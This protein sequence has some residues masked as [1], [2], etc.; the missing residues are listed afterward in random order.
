MNK[1]NRRN[2]IKAG[3]ALLAVGSLPL[4]L[5]EIA[6]GKSSPENFTFAY[7]SDS[8]ITH[9]KGSSFVNNWDRGLIRAVAEAN[10][11]T[12]RPDFILYGGDI[13]QLGTPAEIDHGLEMLGGLRDNMFQSSR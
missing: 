9:L 8:H 1:M 6:F 5:V 7:I 4:T 10:L 11:L 3:G 12:P 13:A 2:F